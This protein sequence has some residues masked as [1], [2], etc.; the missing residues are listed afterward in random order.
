MPRTKN[1]IR[2]TNS[3]RR[4]RRP[5]LTLIASAI[6]ALVLLYHGISIHKDAAKYLDVRNNAILPAKRISLDSRPLEELERYQLPHGDFFFGPHSHSVRIPPNEMIERSWTPDQQIL[7]NDTDID[8]GV[9]RARCASYNFPFPEIDPKTPI[10]RR[11]LFLGSLIAD[12]SLE[13][14]AAVGTEAYNMFHSVIYI[15]GNVT[16]NLTPRKWRYLEDERPS[17]KLHQ[18]YQLFGPRT[19]VRN[20]KQIK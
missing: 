8:V 19:K 3:S 11:R 6:L 18:L 14:L 15:E 12:D 10:K 17:K 1:T 5:K 2:R 4:G 13:V 9:E 16:H 20:I 7:L